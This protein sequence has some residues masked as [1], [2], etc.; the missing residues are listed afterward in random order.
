[1][2]FEGHYEKI[3]TKDDREAARI[4]KLAAD[5]GDADAQVYL[6]KFYRDGL[7]GLTKDEREAARLYKL[8]ADQGNDYAIQALQRLTSGR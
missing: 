2:L 8:A 1:L 6:G 7:S 5:Q 4:L 3:F